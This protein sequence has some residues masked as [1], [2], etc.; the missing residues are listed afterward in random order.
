VGKVVE[1]WT[2]PD[3][4]F[5]RKREKREARSKKQEARNAVAKRRER[6]GALL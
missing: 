3:K 4:L 5:L 2:T 6:G 1:C